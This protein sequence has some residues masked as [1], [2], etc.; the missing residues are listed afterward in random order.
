MIN[1]PEEKNS[2]FTTKINTVTN[3]DSTNNDMNYMSKLYSTNMLNATNVGLFSHDDG[4]TS[5]DGS[6]N[7]DVSKGK[8][9]IDNLLSKTSKRRNTSSFTTWLRS[10]IRISKI[11]TRSTKMLSKLLMRFSKTWIKM[12]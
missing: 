9:H 10:C 11:T 6:I 4:Y 12:I 2:K 1:N 8:L 7:S 3:P 5:S